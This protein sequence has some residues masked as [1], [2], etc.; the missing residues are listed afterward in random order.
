M[1]SVGLTTPRPQYLCEDVRSPTPTMATEQMQH[2]VY[3]SEGEG[4]DYEY[5]IV[6]DLVNCSISS[7][8]FRLNDE[9]MGMVRTIALSHNKQRVVLVYNVTHPLAHLQGMCFRLRPG[10]LRRWWYFDTAQT[11]SCPST[12]SRVKSNG[13]TTTAC[14]RTCLFQAQSISIG[15]CE[16]PDF[17]FAKKKRG[18]C[19]PSVDHH[20]TMPHRMSQKHAPSP[21]RG[22]R[23]TS[24][25]VR[26]CA[27]D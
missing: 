10:R 15:Q 20:T 18:V 25:P 3:D 24:Q 16:R 27:C 26:G 23:C 13:Q 12:T 4:Q 22:G 21:C 8:K 1:V 5:R 2:F 9:N 11:C 19:L 6:L 17:G 7:D 14:T